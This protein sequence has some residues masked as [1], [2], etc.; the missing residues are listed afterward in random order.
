MFEII[1]NY[2]DNP[3]QKPPLVSSSAKKDRAT[4]EAKLKE[5]EKKLQKEGAGLQLSQGCESPGLKPAGTAKEWM[6]IG[7]KEGHL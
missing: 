3:S 1:H 4:L 7:V 5:Y 2:L 6:K